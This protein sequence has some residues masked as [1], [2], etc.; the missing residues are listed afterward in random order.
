MLL[1]FDRLFSLELNARIDTNLSM[2]LSEDGDVLEELLTEE[3]VEKENDLIVY[4]DDINTF[5]HVID[6]LETIC[7]H[8][9][10]QAEQCTYIIHY[11]GKCTVENGSFNK[12]KPMCLALLDSGLSATIE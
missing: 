6:C 7:S 12:L 2:S 1:K 8:N 9:S 3:K 11:N 5:D 10:I 4:N